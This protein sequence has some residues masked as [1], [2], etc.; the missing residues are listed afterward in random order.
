MVGVVTPAGD[1]T[2][3]AQ[4]NAAAVPRFSATSQGGGV[5]PPVFTRQAEL[6]WSARRGASGASLTRINTFGPLWT[7]RSPLGFGI[8]VRSQPTATGSATF[9][10][11]ALTTALNS[12]SLSRCSGGNWSYGTKHGCVFASASL[13]GP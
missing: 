3:S 1:V 2:N 12:A 8:A 6:R 4:S 9:V 7:L 13:I 11:A 5:L 10:A